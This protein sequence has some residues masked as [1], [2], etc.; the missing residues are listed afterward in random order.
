MHIAGLRVEADIISVH[1]HIWLHTAWSAVYGERVLST[2]HT[3]VWCSG[4]QCSLNFLF[5]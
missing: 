1:I 2:L 4:K 3:K 5:Y